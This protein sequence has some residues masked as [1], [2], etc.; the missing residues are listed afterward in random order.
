MLGDFNFLVFASKDALA[1]ADVSY[2]QTVGAN[3]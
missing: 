2:A 1:E 3:P